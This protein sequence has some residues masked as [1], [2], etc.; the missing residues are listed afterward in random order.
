MDLS[1]D[2][3]LYH[4]LLEEQEVP[5]WAMVVLDIHLL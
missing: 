4:P 3:V 5:Q 1:Q 2:M